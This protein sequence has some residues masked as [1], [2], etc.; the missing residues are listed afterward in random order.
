[1]KKLLLFLN[2][3]TWLWVG[4]ACS[5]DDDVLAP[6]VLEPN[7]P[8]KYFNMNEKD[9]LAL[10]ISLRNFG[11]TELDSFINSEEEY[12]G[13]DKIEYRHYYYQGVVFNTLWDTNE[14]IYR[15]WRVAIVE[16]E[17]LPTGYSL[18]ATLGDLE[19][20]SKLEIEGDDRASGGIPK[21]IFNCP[22]IR[23]Y[24]R[25]KGFTGAI[26]K[27]I[28]NVANTLL[29]LEITGT[30]LSV[31]PEEIGELVNVN[32]PNLSYNEFQ[33]TPPL[34]LRNFQCSAWCHNNYFDDM[35]W[36]MFTE[37]PG[38][39]VD[40]IVRSIPLLY[41]NCLSGEIPEEV[42]ASENWVF[43]RECLERQREGYG[44]NNWP[45]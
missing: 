29:E 7:E 36:R 21:E 4:M 28:A 11:I 31:L 16:P 33:G 45:K 22:L 23:L 38:Y 39:G 26:P 25:G 44:F 27:E 24:I 20:L 10:A 41:V 32:T 14:N 13:P 17:L 15:L 37:F 1:M 40:P 3:F 6:E 9:S 30:S 34:S 19:R 35:D 5:S 42:L 2:V 18:S 8:V 12:I 43:Y